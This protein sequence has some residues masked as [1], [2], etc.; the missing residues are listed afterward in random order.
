MLEYINTPQDIKRFSDEQISALADEIRESIIAQVSR[1]GGHL[2][3]N[4]GAV[5]LTIALHRTFDCPKDKLLFD[6]GHQCYAH[7]LLTGRFS[8]FHSLRQFGGMSGFTNRLES[9]YDTVIAGHSGPT[10][11]AS[12]GIAHAN[13]MS[14]DDSFVVCVIGDGSFY[15]RHGL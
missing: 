12:L 11:S 5:E 3:S 2:A 7:K 6:V 4:L 14:G 15:Q 13:R 10:L 1:T 9:E 8:K